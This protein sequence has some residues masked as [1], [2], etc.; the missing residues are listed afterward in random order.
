MEPPAPSLSEL[1][2][3]FSQDPSSNPTAVLTLVF[4]MDQ[5]YVWSKMHSQWLFALA[6]TQ[7]RK[8][9]FFCLER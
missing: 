3:G 1:L 9:P 5:K 6:E 7:S 4:S 2:P 8:L